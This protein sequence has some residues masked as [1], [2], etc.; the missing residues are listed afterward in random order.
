MTIKQYSQLKPFEQ[1]LSSAVN[2]SYVRALGSTTREQLHIIYKEI[3][4]EEST[5]L[6]SCSSCVIK[7]LKRLGEAYFEFKNK[8][9]KRNKEDEQ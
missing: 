9:T 7:G 4:K 3:F 6:Y 2:G 5:L 1:Y 8:L